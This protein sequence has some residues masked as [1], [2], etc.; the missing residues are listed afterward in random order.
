MNLCCFIFFLQPT[1]EILSLFVKTPSL[2]YLSYDCFQLGIAIGIILIVIPAAISRVIPLH[3]YSCVL[4]FSVSTVTLPT[5]PS[6][7]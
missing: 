6:E 1:T 4:C 5:R 2:S 3:L 7:S